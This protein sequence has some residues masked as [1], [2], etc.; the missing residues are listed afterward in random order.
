MPP[1]FLYRYRSFKNERDEKNL[2]TNLLWFAD[3]KE[4]NDPMDC[5]PHY[6]FENGDELAIAHFRKQTFFRAI[7]L[8]HPMANG[9][10][11]ERHMI[12][13]HNKYPAMNDAFWL[14]AREVVERQVRN[15]GVLCLTETGHCPVMYYHYADAHKGMCLKYR[16]ADL[17]DYVEPVQYTLD[18]PE[19]DF[20]AED[21]SDDFN[22]LF[23]TKYLSWQYEKEWRLI[24][25]S[26][27][28]TKEPRH[29]LYPT[30]LLEGVIYGMYMPQHE[31]ERIA[32]LLH[33]SGRHVILYEAKLKT[34]SFL[35]DIVECGTT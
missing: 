33:A 16:T 20:F 9:V 5:K 13:Y 25:F 18:Y 17:F 21:Q 27:D 1:E 3:P 29:L 31:R 15:V 7:K 22:K 24:E 14:F 6:R 28:F 4:F 8:E 32:T 26:R 30:P 34:G 35:L 23:L 19:V 2:T 12:E 11:V 10:E